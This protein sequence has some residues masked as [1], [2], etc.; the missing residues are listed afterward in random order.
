M[1]M[2]G[3]GT[4]DGGHHNK[5]VSIPEYTQRRKFRLRYLGDP[6]GIGSF[7]YR[8]SAAG[9]RSAVAGVGFKRG[10]WRIP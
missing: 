5:A 3:V 2:A 8:I 10:L 4:D 1:S 6:R 7:P 9:G